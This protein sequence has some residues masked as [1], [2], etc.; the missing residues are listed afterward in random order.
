MKTK[1]KQAVKLLLGFMAIIFSNLGWM[2]I[3]TDKPIMYL[4]FTPILLLSACVGARSLQAWI[5]MEDF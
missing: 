2:S 1:D 4:L 3:C 5:C